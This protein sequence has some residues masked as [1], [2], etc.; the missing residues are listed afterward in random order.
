MSDESFDIN[1]LGMLI[2]QISPSSLVAHMDR[3]RPYDGQ[4]HTDLGWRGQQEVRGLTMRDI[5]DCFIRGCY[6]ASGLPIEQWPGTVYD[7]PWD[8]MDVIAVAQNMSCN[9]EK[10]MGV[11]P[12]LG[13]YRLADPS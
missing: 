9:I 5:R 10:Y 3:D 1:D 7:L 12:N 2:E 6:E 8:E 4:P 11:Y 13:P